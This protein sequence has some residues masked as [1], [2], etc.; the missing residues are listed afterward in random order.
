MRYYIKFTINTYSGECLALTIQG[1]PI[2]SGLINI[3]CESLVEQINKIEDPTRGPV[4]VEEVCRWAVP[5]YSVEYEG[6]LDAVITCG[7][8]V[9]NDDL[10]PNLDF[11]TALGAT[12]ITAM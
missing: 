6:E 2:E 1:T 8:V 3:D 12:N 7:D 10:T 4:T 11:L 9:L 5:R